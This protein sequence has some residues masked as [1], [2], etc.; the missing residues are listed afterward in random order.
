MVEFSSYNDLPA[1]T[2]D[3]YSFRMVPDKVWG[4][5]QDIYSLVKL[6]KPVIEKGFNSVLYPLTDINHLN[7][8]IMEELKPIHEEWCGEELISHNIHGIRSYNKGAKL[9]IHRD[10]I[11]SHHIS[12]IVMLEKDK[13]WR[14]ELESH[15]KDIVKIDLNYG[16]MLMYESAKCRHARTIPFTGNIFHNFY[17]HYSLKNW[18]YIGK[19]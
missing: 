13:E 7:D 10:H 3:G 15:S 8:L 14:L 9:P 4:Y 1:F 19:N 18:K 17:I 2:P 6:R 12:C 5:I 11:Q 16:G